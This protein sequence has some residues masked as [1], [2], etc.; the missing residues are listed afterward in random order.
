MD[1]TDITPGPVLATIGTDTD[2]AV[3]ERATAIALDKGRKVILIDRSAETLTG[4]T[5]YD[6]WRGDDDYRPDSDET[7]DPAIARREGRNQLARRIEAVATTGVEVGGWFPTTE[8]IDGIRDAIHRFDGAV[9]V[10]PASVR[11][12]GIADRIRGM[13]TSS[14][15]ELA[16]RVVLAE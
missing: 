3:V 14:L 4:A 5:P 9:L 10:V 2:D 7:F 16:T 15:E 12:P 11:A 8:G 6:D 13:S 1:N